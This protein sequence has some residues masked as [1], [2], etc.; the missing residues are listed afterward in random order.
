MPDDFS[1][2]L[3]NTP[4]QEGQGLAEN[5]GE[6][7]DDQSSSPDGLS[8]E[9]LKQLE[10]VSLDKLPENHPLRRSV[11][12]RER[13]LQADYTR[14]TQALAEEKGRIYDTMIQRLAQQG[15]NPT[16]DQREALKDRIRQGDFDSV[17][18]L[19]SHEI[20]ARVAP[21]L[22]KFTMQQVL[23][24]AAQMHPYVQTKAQEVS[25]LI[26]SDP[27]YSRMAA[28]NDMEFA[29]IVL[30][31][32]AASIER[33][34]LLEAVKTKDAEIAKLKKSLE[35]QDSAIGRRLPPSTSRTGGATATRSSG[36]A[37]FWDAAAS[38]AQE[39]GIDLGPHV[40][41]PR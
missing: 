16:P 31:Q 13:N 34:E 17:G 40:P 11:V 28:M 5:L 15:V 27:R 6:G 2:D 12:E 33:A 26:Q 38:A 36:G 8:P 21:T 19:V 24:E 29:P 30:A 41:R 22:Q 14:K 32:A 3:T 23:H 18:E 10:G 25:A 7:A 4:D 20:Q 37:N 39:L 9:F 1:D 35:A